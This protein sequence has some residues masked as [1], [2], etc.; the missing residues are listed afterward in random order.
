MVTNAQSPLTHRT[1]ERRSAGLRDSADRSAAAGRPARLALA[2]VDA[3][4]AGA[5]RTFLAGD[6]FSQNGL[7]RRRQADGPRRRASGRRRERRRSPQRRQTGAVQRFARIDVAEAGD[8]P[9]I[10]QRHFQRDAL[11][12]QR[13][14]QRRGAEGRSERLRPHRR[15][16]LVRGGRPSPTRS[17][18]PKRRGSL[19]VTVTPFDSVNTT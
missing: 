5:I 11:A 4:A 9:L 16:R 2:L 15:E 19:N 3:E 8:D 17:I 6:R 18:T 13:P 10:E 1:V 7:D 14:R 12:G